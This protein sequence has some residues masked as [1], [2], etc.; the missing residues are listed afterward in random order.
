MDT[1][2]F[3]VCEICIHLVLSKRWIRREYYFE[4]RNC[5]VHARSAKNVFRNP[6]CQAIKAYKAVIKDCFGTCTAL[7]LMLT[8]RVKF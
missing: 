2:F 7:Q 3:I 4:S 8:E 6:H 1:V 5:D